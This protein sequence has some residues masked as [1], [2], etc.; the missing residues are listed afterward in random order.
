MEAEWGELKRF[1]DDNIKAPSLY[2]KSGKIEPVHLKKRE[3]EQLVNG[4]VQTLTASL[5]EVMNAQKQHSES[6][7]NPSSALIEQMKRIKKIHD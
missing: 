1:V 3:R 7:G 6:T 5:N 4:M 2:V